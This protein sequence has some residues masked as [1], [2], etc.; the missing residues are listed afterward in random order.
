MARLAVKGNPLFEV[1]DYEYRKAGI[2][3]SVDTVRHFKESLPK[4]SK[5]YLILGADTFEFIHAWKAVDELMRM[6]DFVVVN[7]PG[8]K[9]RQKRPHVSVLMPDIGISST[10]IRRRLKQKKDIRYLVP[11]AVRR[12]IERNHLYQ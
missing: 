11:D 9:F 7:R 5:I 8:Y 2:S 1:S 3:Y 6:V 4:R 12:Y 10:A